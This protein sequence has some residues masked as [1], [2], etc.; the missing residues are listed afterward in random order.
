MRSI[1]QMKLNTRSILFKLLVSFWTII[2]LF[3]SFHIVSLIM[4]RNNIHDEI[5]KYNDANLTYTTNGFEQYFELLNSVLL[6][7]YTGDNLEK[8]NHPSIDYVAAGQVINDLQHTTANSQL[9]LNNLF[10]Y[11]AKLSL[12]LEKNRGSSNPETMFSEH[13]VNPRYTYEFWKREFAEPFTYK[14]YPSAT[15]TESSGTAYSSQ[16]DLVI[17]YMVKSPVYPDFIM[18]AFIDFTKLYKAYHQSINENF[19][20]I[21]PQGQ[22][23]FSSDQTGKH[24]LPALDPGKKWVKYNGN[25]YFYKKGTVTGLTYVNIVSDGSISAQ[26]FRQS[27]TLLLLLVI[28]IIVSVTVSVFSSLR[29]NN[30]VKKIV[31]SIR[32]LNEKKELG[33]KPVNEL[34][35]ISENIGRMM[36]LNRDTLTDLEEKKSLLRYYSLMNRLKRI[37]SGFQETLQPEM[38]RKYRF[39]L[40]QLTFKMQFW[41]EMQGDEERATYFFREFVNQAMGLD[42]KDSQTFQIEANQILSI[43][44]PEDEDERWLDVLHKIKS[45]LDADSHY[46]FFT[47]AVSSMYEHSSQMTACYE[48]T[49]AMIKQRPFDDKTHILL[50]S[51]VV[52]EPFLL[53]AS[54]EQELQTNLQVGSDAQVLH[55]LLRTVRHMKKKSFSTMRFHRFAEEIADRVIRV[56]HGLQLETRI[57]SAMLGSIPH[58]HTLCEI[59]Q[60]FEKLISEACR[61]VRMKNEEHDPIVHFVMSYMQAHY[62]E[63]ITLDHVASKLNITGGYLSTYF[64]EK[65]GTNFVDYV[66]EFRVKLATDLLLKQ[67]LKIQDVA[68]AVGYQTMRSFNRTFKNLT[69][70]TPSEYRKSR[71]LESESVS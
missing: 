65:T 9:Y 54:L 31:E 6:S 23:L 49:L 35:L 38:E 44:Y 1:L 34:E 42:I 62:A 56:L 20:M 67:E 37:R 17:P 45:V 69:G 26:L 4:Y 61:Q 55:S 7:M 47:I 21:S 68:T 16:S 48:E 24:E 2:L 33:G 30:P 25:Y 40:F 39:V 58:I 28:S 63:D 14:L 53:P 43:L 5:I 51:E 10:V 59:E 18:L 66:N 50:G 64:K 60:F 32:H 36:K 12:V 57:I 29:F 3:V 22:T 11:D 19:Y 46:C 27:L 41:E 13:Y 15:F 8:L 71:A 52:E 70:V